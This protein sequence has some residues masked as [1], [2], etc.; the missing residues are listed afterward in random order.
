MMCQEV[1]ELMQRYIDGDLDE[2]ETSLMM[3]HVGQCPD[4]AAM[5]DRLKRL[6]SE[7]EQLPRVVPRYSLVDAILPELE[8]LNELEIRTAPADEILEAAPLRSRRSLRPGR[9]LLRRLSTVVALGVVVGLLIFT[10]PDQ[11]PFGSNSSGTNEAG[12]SLDKQNNEKSVIQES[13]TNTLKVEQ[14]AP[15][16]KGTGGADDQ[17]AD[18]ADP[19]ESDP[20]EK[21][22]N[23]VKI[24]GNETMPAATPSFN[25][26][27]SEPPANPDTPVS[28]RGDVDRSASASGEA[29]SSGSPAASASEEVPQSAG[30][31]AED[32]DQGK[33]AFGS[34]APDA[35]VS[36]VSPDGK[37]RAVT[38][39]GTATI[40]IYK[41][42]DNSLLFDSAAREG[43]IENLTWSPES[44]YLYYSWIDAEGSRTEL[45]FDI[46][47]V[48]ESNR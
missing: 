43:S 23:D 17:H 22:P 15:A 37:W 6:S 21:A 12:P 18:R 8:R 1:M 40:Q 42:E 14:Q 2:Q 26:S 13:N 10:Q 45:M 20:G 11:W 4:C 27:T 16:S 41:S 29:S 24:T 34:G 38:S 28:N 30:I 25:A 32:G 31:M 44:T 19:R 33:M 3:D 35:A 48:Q 36:V 39:E 9:D 5:L 7:L 47:G 46:E